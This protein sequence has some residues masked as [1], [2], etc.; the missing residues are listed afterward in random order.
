VEF[1][2]SQNVPLAQLLGYE[3][4]GENTMNAGDWQKALEYAAHEREIA[5]RVHS[6]ERYAWTYMVTGVSYK[7]SGD[8]EAAERELREGMAAAESIGEQRL[9][10][11]L[12]GN[13]A[14]VLADSGRI[15]EAFRTARENYT[16]CEALGLLYS[17]AEG[18]RCLAHVH[19]RNGD[20]EETLRLCDE[21]LELIGEGKSRI[22]RL[23]LGPL[24]VEA[25]FASGHRD[26]ANRRLVEY[27]ELLSVCQSP[28]CEREVARLKELMNSRTS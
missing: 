22:S 23:W 3:F 21:I 18:R 15:D 12:K 10:L 1:G 14:I 4:L 19:F 27:E 16:A 13:L 2:N 5:A 25:L 9:A 24:H 26:E 17:R 28:G 6:R 20:L 11:L 7:L 8:Q